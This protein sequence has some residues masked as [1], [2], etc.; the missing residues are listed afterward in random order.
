MSVFL[1]LDHFEN[2]R[3]S[4]S[5]KAQSGITVSIFAPDGVRV[6]I[7]GSRPIN[8]VVTG[9]GAKVNGVDWNV[10]GLGCSGAACGEMT[11]S[12]Y[13]PPNNLPDPPF[14]TLTAVSKADPTAKASL[15]LH[16]ID[17]VVKWLE[18]AEEND[19]SM[20]TI[21]VRAPWTADAEARVV[22]LDEE[23]RL[24]P[25]A[26]SDGLKYFLETEVALEV[27]DGLRNRRIISTEDACSLLLYY[28]END[29]YPEW[30]NR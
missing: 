13:L 10:S 5:C 25:D 12:A 20:K 14:V 29:A 19:V 26:L 9:T 28:A 1:S 3:N 23:S 30:A 7:G 16:I 22:A 18:S 8:A 4:A 21:C 27:L 6:P 11:E 17:P 24:P 2:R 15:T